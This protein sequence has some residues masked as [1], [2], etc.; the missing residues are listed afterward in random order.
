MAGGFQSTVQ[1]RAKPKEV[2]D[3]LASGANTGMEVESS[4][5]NAMTVSLKRKI[6]FF[7][8]ETLDCT[9]NDLRD[10]CRIVMNGSNVLRSNVTEDAKGMVTRVSDALIERFRT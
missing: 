8:Y 3:F 2:Y 6:G 10:S 5:P 4:D 7:R 9:I 1:V